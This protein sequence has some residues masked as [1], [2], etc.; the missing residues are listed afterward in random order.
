MRAL[1]I[2]SSEATASAVASMAWVVIR[3]LAL[4]DSEEG[5]TTRGGSR[6]ASPECSV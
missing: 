1:M 3:T 2:V 4:S 6:E 5:K